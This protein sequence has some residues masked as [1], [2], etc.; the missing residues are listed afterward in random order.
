M[1]AFFKIRPILYTIAVLCVAVMAANQYIS[2]RSKPANNPWI[3][4]DVISGDRFMVERNDQ[5]LEVKLCGIS[6]GSKDSLRSL[7]A[8]GNGSV[9]LEKISKQNEFSHE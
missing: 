2:R 7:L 5:T 6:E 1:K 3:V 9:A 4:V 8:Q